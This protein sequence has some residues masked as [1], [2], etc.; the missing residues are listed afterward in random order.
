MGFGDRQRKNKRAGNRHKIVESR[1]LERGKA[2]H[3]G[4]KGVKGGL[5]V[6]CLHDCRGGVSSGGPGLGHRKRRHH[7]QTFGGRF[8]R[9]AIEF[10]GETAL[11]SLG[12][13]LFPEPFCFPRAHSASPTG[14]SGTSFSPQ[15]RV[16]HVRA[17][18]SGRG[19]TKVIISLVIGCWNFS[20]RACRCSL[21]LMSPPMLAPQPS[22]IFS[23]P[24]PPY[25]PSPKIG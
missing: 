15:S 11:T 7:Q 16:F 19:A 1:Q 3:E 12:R 17:I 5:G 24:E 8:N 13:G 10:D 21:R 20:I 9:A 22:P 14:S 23:T 2:A 4:G 18:W 6:V 25:L